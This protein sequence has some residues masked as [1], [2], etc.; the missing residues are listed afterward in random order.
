MQ[1]P[2]MHLPYLAGDSPNAEVDRSLVRRETMIALVKFHLARAQC[3]MKNL[4][5]QHRTKRSFNSGDWVWLKLQPYRQLTIKQRP[6]QKLSPKYYGPFQVIDAVGKVAYKL[7]LP[8]DARVHNVFHV[9]QLKRFQGTLPMAAH[10][11]S[12]FQGQASSAPVLPAAILEHRTV[13]I[14]GKDQLQYLVHWKDFPSHETTWENAT[15]FVTQ[16]PTFVV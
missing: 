5:D 9:S 7:K 3:R 10:I 2:P 8:T 16:F 13:H 6:N 12:W 14:Q 1:A 11:P 15:D 4:A